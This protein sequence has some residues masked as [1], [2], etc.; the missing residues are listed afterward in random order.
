MEDELGGT[1][2]Q[3]IPI[4]SPYNVGFSPFPPPPVS[5]PKSQVKLHAYY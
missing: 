4:A 2:K 1:I 3:D 5:P